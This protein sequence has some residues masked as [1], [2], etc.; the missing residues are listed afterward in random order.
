MLTCGDAAQ[1]ETL[2]RLKHLLGGR[3]ILFTL[4]GSAA[5]REYGLSRTANDLDFV[6]D[7]YEPAMEILNASGEF[8]AVFDDH[9]DTTQRTCTKRDTKTG[10][11]IDFL[12]SGIRINDGSRWVMGRKYRDPM[13]IPTATGMG[14]AALLPTLIAMKL[15]SAI[16]GE[17]ILKCGA[18]TG[19]SRDKIQ[20]D[21]SDVRELIATCG[22]GRSLTT[23]QR[24]DSKLL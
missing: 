13:P 4:V 19:R 18:D 2:E 14:D 12:K 16:S 22:L 20:K 24:A 6:V 9:P 7:P 3:K 15:N 21:M 1:N 11:R 23:G 5:C 8:E 10:V 17:D